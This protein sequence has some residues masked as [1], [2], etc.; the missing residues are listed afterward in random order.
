MKLDKIKSK[1][2][3]FIFKLANAN[4]KLKF[5]TLTKEGNFNLVIFIVMSVSDLEN[6]NE[7]CCTD[8]GHLGGGRRVTLKIEMIDVVQIQDILVVGEE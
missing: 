3:R 4:F 2:I 1:Y 5:H 8:T 7:R 6:R